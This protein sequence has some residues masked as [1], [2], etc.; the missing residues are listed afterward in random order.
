MIGGNR[1]DGTTH[2]PRFVAIDLSLSSKM[3]AQ[4]GGVALAAALCACGTA[5]ALNMRGSEKKAASSKSSGSG[6][7]G[8][9]RKAKTLGVLALASGAGAASGSAAAA[10]DPTA[11]LY[12]TSE[13][14][15][16]HGKNAWIN[17][18]AGVTR[19]LPTFNAP[20][21]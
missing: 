15:G 11:D 20:G 5:D 14:R 10:A 1:W 12:T 7:S 21:F 8:M 19:E 18:I 9:V 16:L 3:A 2:R 4:V 6:L 17:E 13:K